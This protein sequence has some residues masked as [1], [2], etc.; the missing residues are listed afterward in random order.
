MPSPSSTSVSP[1]APKSRWILSAVVGAVAIAAVATIAA[2]LV[3]KHG[4][5]RATGRRRQRTRPGTPPSSDRIFD[6]ASEFEEGQDD[7]QGDGQD[8]PDADGKVV[9]SQVFGGAL[10]EED[11]AFIVATFTQCYDEMNIEDVKRANAMGEAIEMTPDDLQVLFV[12]LTNMEDKEERFKAVCLFS[13]LLENEKNAINCAPFII[14]YLKVNLA[15]VTDPIIKYLLVDMI[16]VL[17]RQ[18][19]STADEFLASTE[20]LSIL[21]GILADPPTAHEATAN[22]AWN[23]LMRILNNATSVSPLLQSPDNVP[24]LT[25]VFNN[26]TN[27][28]LDMKWRE[29]FALTFHLICNLAS[30]ADWAVLLPHWTRESHPHEKVTGLIKETE[31][32]HLQSS[33][34][35]TVTILMNA[36]YEMDKFEDLGDEFLDVFLSMHTSMVYSNDFFANRLLDSG[37][38]HAFLTQPQVKS[39][40]KL[41]GIMHAVLTSFRSRAQ[42]IDQLTTHAPHVYTH[43]YANLSTPAARYG[44][45]FLLALDPAAMPAPDFKLLRALM[46][47]M[48][49][50]L[51]EAAGDELDLEPTVYLLDDLHSYLVYDR[52]PDARTLLLDD[53]NEAF[54]TLVRTCAL[55][56]KL[57]VR[58]ELAQV[59]S[60]MLQVVPGRGLPLAV[61]AV[62]S[63]YLSQMHTMLAETV[64]LVASVVK[65]YRTRPEEVDDSMVEMVSQRVEAVEAVVFPLLRGLDPAVVRY[66]W[67]GDGDGNVNGQGVGVGEGKQCLQDVF[68]LC[69]TLLELLV[70]DTSGR[71]FPLM[72]L[73]R[74][75]TDYVAL[76]ESKGGMKAAYSD[77]FGEFAQ[78]GKLADGSQLVLNL[79]YSP[80]VLGVGLVHYDELRQSIL[81]LAPAMAFTMS[82]F[83]YEALARDLCGILLQ[84]PPRTFFGY[85]E[86]AILKYPIALSTSS[87]DHRPHRMP[88]REL[89]LRTIIRDPIKDK[90]HWASTSGNLYTGHR[91]NMIVN[92]SH[93]LQT[94]RGSHG[95]RKG[96]IGFVVHATPE[97]CP[98]VGW[99]TYAGEIK[100][101]RYLF[102]EEAGGDGQVTYAV[103]FGSGYAWHNGQVRYMNEQVNTPGPMTF[104][105]DL[106][107]G[108]MLA[109]IGTKPL[110]L[111]FADVDTSRT[112]YPVLF[113]LGNSSSE[114]RFDAALPDGFTPIARAPRDWL[115]AHPDAAQQ[116]VDDDDN[117]HDD[118]PQVVKPYMPLIAGAHVAAPPRNPKVQFYYEMDAVPAQPLVAAGFMQGVLATLW[119]ATRGLE[120]V[121]QFIPPAGTPVEQSVVWQEQVPRLVAWLAGQ[122][123]EGEAE[124]MEPQFPVEFEEVEPELG[125]GWK[126]LKQETEY[127]PQPSTL[128]VCGHFG[129]PRLLSASQ[130]AL[131]KPWAGTPLR[132]GLAIIS[133]PASSSTTAPSLIVTKGDLDPVQPSDVFHLVQEDTSEE[134]YM[135]VVIGFKRV[136]V[137]LHMDVE[138]EGEWRLKGAVVRGK[139]ANVTRRV[140]GH[141]G[142]VHRSVNEDEDED[143]DEDDENDSDD[144]IENGSDD[145]GEVVPEAELN[146]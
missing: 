135:P 52:R 132:L 23:A 45:P 36:V 92:P 17:T 72:R 64:P 30:D 145:E 114:A 50:M 118:E 18:V 63:P 48:Q 123:K 90:V 143:E 74:L 76:R 21:L 97:S 47:K 111:V 14:A 70:V 131:E 109:R 25:T 91:G 1:A 126:V 67:T 31:Q 59:L 94:V 56:G 38:L 87:P 53:P 82:R 125:G 129:D 6:D 39:H 146:V 122:Y 35:V 128:I 140:L 121:V 16:A 61:E 112:W 4:A 26:L 104:I 11:I 28:L 27:T 124:D 69:R 130:G 80:H 102:R 85:A 96:K 138:E 73:S 116:H 60:D 100:A 127:D 33:G 3:Q 10:S 88:V 77:A 136:E 108:H 98:C 79:L 7:G 110:Q 141:W 71:A 24:L 107:K 86:L 51:D 22:T 105:L 62:Y 134:I 46:A 12:A 44:V 19:K 15:D 41:M 144:E 120:L 58:P 9:A 65:D 115:V 139:E 99:T 142:L 42:L 84:S 103:Q 68:T 81:D 119:V 5:N 137:Y 43:A 89:I 93:V 34:Y 78:D 106:D 75:L 83:N 66:L 95:V 8:R 20:L 55:H 2:V 117:E 49:H 113:Q 29:M 13:A 57:R 133:A 54:T 101:N 37:K 40:G 32:E